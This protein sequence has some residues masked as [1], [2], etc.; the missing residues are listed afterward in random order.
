MRCHCP[1]GLARCELKRV[2]DWF[3]E[4]S[5]VQYDVEVSVASFRVLQGEALDSCACVRSMQTEFIYVLQ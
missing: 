3:E 5:Y 4:D 2:L 1:D